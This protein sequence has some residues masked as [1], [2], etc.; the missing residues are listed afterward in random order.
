MHSAS[1]VSILKQNVL[2]V[3][4]LKNPLLKIS[5][6]DK[7]TWALYCGFTNDT[8]NINGKIVVP[9]RTNGRI[10]KENPF[11]IT[12]GHERNIQGNENL[13]RIGKEMAQKQCLQPVNSVSLPDI[14][15]SNNHTNTILNLYKQFKGLFTRVG[16]IPSDRKITHFHSPY[17]PI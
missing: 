6:V 17:K 1:P 3:L 10:I 12:S 9:V 8:I 14:C 16:K 2:H 13:P 4:K 15:R 11:F 5:P 7:K